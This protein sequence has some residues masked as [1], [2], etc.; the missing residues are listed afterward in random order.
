MHAVCIISACIYIYIYTHTYALCIFRVH[1][2]IYIYV[3][4]FIYIYIIYDMHGD[5]THLTLHHH[6]DKVLHDSWYASCSSALWVREVIHDLRLRRSFNDTRNIYGSDLNRMLS[7]HFSPVSECGSDRSP[8]CWPM[9]AEDRSGPVP[10]TYTLNYR[11]IA[12][13]SI[14]WYIDS[15]TNT[16]KAG[17]PLNVLI[18]TEG[19]YIYIYICT[20]I[21]IWPISQPLRM[22]AVCILA[23]VHAQLRNAALDGSAANCSSL[24]SKLE[25]VK[26]LKQSL[27]CRQPRQRLRKG[28]Y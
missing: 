9:H 15:M 20:Y 4:L 11:V 24:G 7:A 5:G 21:Y 13:N 2:Y 3:Y 27:I 23:F 1:E 22:H 12:D 6:I 19:I 26:I 16:P 17:D 28:Q 10:Y 14:I 8:Q 25:A 18:G